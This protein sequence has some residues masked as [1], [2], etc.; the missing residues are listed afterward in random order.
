MS[1]RKEERERDGE[2]EVVREREEEEEWGREGR[3]RQKGDLFKGMFSFIH[4]T[5]DSR[6]DF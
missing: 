2:G 6:W 3:E 4:M 1:W 5:G